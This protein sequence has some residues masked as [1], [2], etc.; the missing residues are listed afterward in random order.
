MCMFFVIQPHTVR[1]KKVNLVAAYLISR[2]GYFKNSC[3][4]L[5]LKQNLSLFY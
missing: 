4:A 5:L 3:I 1:I 2:Y